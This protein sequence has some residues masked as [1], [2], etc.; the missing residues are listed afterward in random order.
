M[1]LPKVTLSLT[2]SKTVPEFETR[3]YLNFIIE[4][5]FAFATC[6]SDPN[7]EYE[8]I[9]TIIFKIY[10]NDFDGENIMCHDAT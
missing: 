6:R 1:S 8:N 2:R 4:G 7:Q 3:Y 9:K 5:C 10:P